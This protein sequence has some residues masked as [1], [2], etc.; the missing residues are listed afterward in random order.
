MDPKFALSYFKHDY[1]RV[2]KQALKKLNKSF[3]KLNLPID[4][5]H[6]MILPDI[7]SMVAGFCVLGADGLVT[8]MYSSDPTARTISQEEYIARV[9]EKGQEL[10]DNISQDLIDATIRTIKSLSPGIV[11]IPA[12]YFVMRLNEGC[13]FDGDS[14]YLIFMDKRAS[15]FVDDYGVVQYAWDPEGE[16]AVTFK[17]SMRYPKNCD[18]GVNHM[19]NGAMADP[20]LQIE[21]VE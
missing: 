15:E 14:L 7:A 19:D 10:G 20:S 13:D 2:I 4:G 21:V 8:D 12:N 9:I 3:G 6:C 11:V 5:T 16:H 1:L 17:I 18:N